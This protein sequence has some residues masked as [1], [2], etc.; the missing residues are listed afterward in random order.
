LYRDKKNDLHM[1]FINLEKVYNKVPREV[2]WECFE[3][4]EVSMAYIRTI[5]DMHEGVN[6]SVRTLALTLNS[7]RVQ[8]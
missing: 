8:L 3:K 6:T 5:K 1:V 2:L 4:K 7:I